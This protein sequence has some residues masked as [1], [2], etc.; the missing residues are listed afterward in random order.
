MVTPD[1][2]YDCDTVT[3]ELTLLR[4][5]PVLPLPGGREYDPADYEQYREWA[6]APDGTRIP[7]SLVCRKGTAQRRQRAVRALRLRQ[8]R[9]L[10]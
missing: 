1:S 10:V 7:M 6:T 3:G 5:R 2:V 4:R 9:D 8:L